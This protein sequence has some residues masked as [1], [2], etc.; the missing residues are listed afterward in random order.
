MIGRGH[1]RTYKV[2]IAT[3]LGHLRKNKE[4]HVEIVEEAQAEFRKLAIAE[5]ESML[6]DARS[7]KGI[8]THLS[9]EVPTVHTDAFDNAIGLLEMT[10]K[11]ARRSSRSTPVSTR[12][13]CAETGSGPISSAPPTLATRT[14]WAPDMGS[15][16]ESVDK[17]GESVDKPV[18]INP[19]I[20]KHLLAERGVIYVEPDTFKGQRMLGI[21]VPE[22]VMDLKYTSQEDADTLLEAKDNILRELDTRLTAILGL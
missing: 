2:K 7:G 15:A 20:A 17:I 18:V 10:K 4:D 14:S 8:S 3:L 16:G 13:S 6:T 21:L 9:L 1:G 5:I 11:R 22:E 19:L 12:D